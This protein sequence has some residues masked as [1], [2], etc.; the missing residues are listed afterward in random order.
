[1]RRADAPAMTDP[2]AYTRSFCFRLLELLDGESDRIS[3]GALKEM[4][5]VLMQ[6]YAHVQQAGWQAPEPPKNYADEWLEMEMQSEAVFE[7]E[8]REQ[9]EREAPQLRSR[10]DG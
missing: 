6:H 3:S 7:A 2:V 10:R 1:M 8:R 5:D 4:S 9:R